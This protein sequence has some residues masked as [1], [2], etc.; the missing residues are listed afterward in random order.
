MQNEASSCEMFAYIIDKVKSVTQNW[1]QRYLSTGGK[2][3][4]LKAIAVAMPIFSMNIFWLPKEV[5]VLRLMQS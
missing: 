1:K 5:Y 4:L 2:E 3:V